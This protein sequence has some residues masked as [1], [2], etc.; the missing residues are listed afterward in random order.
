[1]SI[2]QS[3][4]AYLYISDRIGFAIIIRS[5][6]MSSLLQMRRGLTFSTKITCVLCSQRNT[7]LIIIRTRA[8]TWALLLRTPNNINHYDKILYIFSCCCFQYSLNLFRPKSCSGN[9][10]WLNMANIW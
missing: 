3:V 9:L 1:M 2:D 7:V 4:F 5:Y 6:S 10:T 8:D